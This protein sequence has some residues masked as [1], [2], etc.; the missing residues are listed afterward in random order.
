MQIQKSAVLI[1]QGLYEKNK[2]KQK[3]QTFSNKGNVQLASCV[4]QVVQSFRLR[5]G[6][7]EIFPENE[8]HDR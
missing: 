6:H 4:T 7:V 8:Y 5:A 1:H 2:T 3:K